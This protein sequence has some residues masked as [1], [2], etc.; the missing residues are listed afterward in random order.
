MPDTEIE[1]IAP[2]PLSAKRQSSW[3]IVSTRMIVYSIIDREHI[4]FCLSERVSSNFEGTG[5]FPPSE[6]L[7]IHETMYIALSNE[8]KVVYICV[9][10]QE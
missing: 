8:F 1:A 3:R 7:S 10:A 4:N 6:G 9:P 2:E 5:P